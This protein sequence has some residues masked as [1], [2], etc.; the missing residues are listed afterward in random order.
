MSKGEVPPIHQLAPVALNA[1]EG[2]RLRFGEA[3]VLI[4]V[5][6]EMTG[7]A[8]MIM[9]EHEPLDTPLHMHA[10]EDEMFYALEGDHVIQV[11]D[12]EHRIGPQGFVFAPRGI[13]HAQRRVVARTGSVL[14]LV[15]PAGLEGFFRELAAAD[16][17]GE[18]GPDAYA[19]ASQRYGITWLS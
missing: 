6:G 16:S 10:H 11:G 17:A 12:E 8:F 15:A 2:E 1:G 14:I 18:L 9:E 5:S 19:R 7:G 13:P 3:E 4:R